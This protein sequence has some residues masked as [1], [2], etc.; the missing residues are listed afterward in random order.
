MKLDARLQRVCW[1]LSDASEGDRKEKRRHDTE[2]QKFL[3]TVFCLARHKRRYVE[4]AADG[5]GD[6][7]V[8][9]MCKSGGCCGQWDRKSLKGNRRQTASA[10]E[11]TEET[12]RKRMIR[13]RSLASAEERRL[14]TVFVMELSDSSSRLRLVRQSRVTAMNCGSDSMVSR[15]LLA[16]TCRSDSNNHPKSQTV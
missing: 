16:M 6:L 9:M 14:R 15:K 8:W 13:G 1:G 3:L 12:R 7:G 4:I 10:L 2:D 5:R 11:E